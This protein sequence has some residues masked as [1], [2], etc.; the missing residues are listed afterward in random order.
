M[1]KGGFRAQFSGIQKVKKTSAEL[2]R[3]MIELEL[4]VEDLD[5]TELYGGVEVETH[6]IHA[7]KLLD[8]AKHAKIEAGTANIV[9]V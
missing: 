1:F 9:F 8:L 5:K 3:E 6:K 4:K 7:K 2:E